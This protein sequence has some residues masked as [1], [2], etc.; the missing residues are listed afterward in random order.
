MKKI[1]LSLVLVLLFPMVVFADETTYFVVYPDNYEYGTPSR[2]EADNAENRLMYNGIT[3]GEGKIVISDWAPSGTITIEEEVPAGYTTKQNRITID[4]NKGEANFVNMKEISN[5]MTGRTIFMYVMIGIIGLLLVICVSSVLIKNKE[6]T[7]LTIL[8]FILMIC[9]FNINIQVKAEEGFVITVKDSSGKTMSNVPVKIYG[10]PVRVDTAPSVKIDANGGHFFDGKDVMYVRLQDGVS[11]SCDFW[12]TLTLEQEENYHHVYR[13]G[14]RVKKE[15]S[16][17]E[18]VEVTSSYVKMVNWEE[19]DSPL[20]EVDGNGGTY[21]SYGTFLSKVYLYNV[22]EVKKYTKSFLRNSYQNIGY[23]NNS[24]CTRYNEYGFADETI[25]SGNKY[26]VCWQEKPDGIYIND[27][28]LFKGNIDECFRYN[29]EGE[30]F[31]ELYDG[32][33]R[34]LLFESFNANNFKVSAYAIMEVHPHPEPGMDHM[35]KAR[36]VFDDDNIV[37]NRIE[38]FSKDIINIEK[39]EV[40][41]HGE[42]YLMLNES[43]LEKVDN[44]YKIKNE[45]NNQK[46][47]DYVNEITYCDMC[48]GKILNCQCGC[49][50]NK[51]TGTV[52]E[53]GCQSAA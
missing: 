13:D 1:F 52:F 26:F 28:I 44:Y 7:T 18:S 30:E 4:L 35:S 15:L 2:S 11:N 23:D 27:S 51:Y 31:K 41:Y 42:T 37:Q 8:I 21:N 33:G 25:V 5:P 40:V 17:C 38:D 20:Y 22:D 39:L 9:L 49:D 50:C 43:D 24:S 12:R 46:L 3:D 48:E 36:K 19:S 53:F 45:S 34:Y 29:D 47:L 6:A 32:N 16:R 14:F 10:S